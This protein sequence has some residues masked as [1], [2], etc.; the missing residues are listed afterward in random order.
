MQLKRAARGWMPFHPLS[1]VT[2]PCG[3]IG[4]DLL[5]ACWWIF[6]QPAGATFKDNNM[7]THFDWRHLRAHVA[8]RGHGLRGH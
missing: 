4:Y 5:S 2:N 7:L 6:Y 3:S 8:E 1:K